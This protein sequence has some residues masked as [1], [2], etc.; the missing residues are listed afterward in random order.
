[1]FRVRRADQN[2]RNA[3]LVIAVKNQ[4]AQAADVVAVGMRAE[5]VHGMNI[6]EQVQLNDPSVNTLAA[7]NQEQVP[8]LDEVG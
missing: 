2:E 1:M 6:I 4:T 3:Y 8:V 5:K 7:V